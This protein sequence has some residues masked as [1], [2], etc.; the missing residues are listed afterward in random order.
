MLTA[1]YSPN[2]LFL[3]PKDFAGFVVLINT[4]SEEKVNCNCL[5]TIVQGRLVVI[6]YTIKKIAKG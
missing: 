6:I 1:E 3:A 2:G 4:N 5:R